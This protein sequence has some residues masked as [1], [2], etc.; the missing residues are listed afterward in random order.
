[1][2]G[3]TPKP[4][5]RSTM[6]WWKKIS[7]QLQGIVVEGLN[8]LIIVGF[9]TLWNHKNDCVSEMLIPD[10]ASTIRKAGEEIGV[11]GD[12]RGQESFSP[13]LLSV[14]RLWRLLCSLFTVLP[15]FGVPHCSCIWSTMNNFFSS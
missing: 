6:D 8:S 4:G 12:G 11:V 1:M 2:Q 7:D 5:D 15:P 13:I 14:Y 3:L 9:W 10:V